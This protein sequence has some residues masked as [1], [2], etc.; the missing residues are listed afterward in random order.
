VNLFKCLQEGSRHLKNHH[1]LEES[2]YS[3]SQ[4]Y[5]W[6]G[7]IYNRKKRSSKL[8]PMHVAETAV[9]VVREYP[10]FGASKGQG[11]MIY[12]QLGYIPQHIYKFLKSIVK[13]LIFQ[14]I[15]IR[16]LLPPRS[17]YTHERPEKPGDIWAED[18]TTIRVAGEKFYVSLLID[19]ASTYYLGV[20]VSRRADADLVEAPVKQALDINEGRGPRRF[21]LS[22]NGTQYISAEHGD[23]LDSLD[24]IQKRIPSCTPEYNGAIEC[25]V[26]EFKNVF[27]NV[28]IN[29]EIK[30]AD[31]GR[32]V[33]DR[34]Q[35]A[36]VESAKRMNLEIPRLCLKGVTPADVHNG[37]AQYRRQINEDY[38]QK[39]QERKEE[40]ELWTKTPWRLVK[41]ILF[42]DNMNNLELMTKFC[43]F[44][45]R[46]LRKLSNLLPEGVG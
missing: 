21:L 32:R 35:R 9:E 5:V 36:V 20:A 19:V 37:T 6:L 38:I 17:S 30:E 15:S 28:W 11:Y 7:G 3:K 1:L 16:G 45:K 40:I 14:E 39:A 41:D 24:I 13:R 25:G 10:H 44:L 23:L 42:E 2:G 4:F 29:W 26:K 43:F 33:I 27:Y 12:H 46:P 31:K 34:I 18:F 8:V 22:D